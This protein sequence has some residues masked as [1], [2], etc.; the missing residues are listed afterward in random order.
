MNRVAV[1][2]LCL[3][4]LY[5]LKGENSNY[6]LLL[7]RAQFF[8]VVIIKICRSRLYLSKAPL[9]VIQQKGLSYE[10]CGGATFPTWRARYS[11]PTLITSDHCQAYG[12]QCIVLCDVIMIKSPI[13]HL[14]VRR[15]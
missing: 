14:C 12:N 8:Q 1:C 4:Q 9:C 10:T 3:S 7:K 6:A 13:V 11:V 5:V 2:S 15:S